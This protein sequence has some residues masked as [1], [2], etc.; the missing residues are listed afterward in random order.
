MVTQQ[1][2]AE[3]TGLSLRIYWV[4]AQGEKVDNMLTFFG[5]GLG[6]GQIVGLISCFSTKLLSLWDHPLRNLGT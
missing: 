3:E 1:V 4:G 2:E 5:E 6:S